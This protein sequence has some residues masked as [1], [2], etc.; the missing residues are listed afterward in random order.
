MTATISESQNDST[1]S[2]NSNSNPPVYQTVG[3]EK[4]YPSRAGEVVAL[5]KMDLTIQRGEF[6]SIRGA[7][8]S[9]K[10]TLLMALGGMSH[11]TSGKILF[12][13]SDLYQLS[14]GQR[15]Q[16]RAQSIGFIF[17]MF[18]LAPYLN[19]M[20]NTLLAWHKSWYKSE[21]GQKPAD[22]AKEILSQLGLSHRLTHRPSALSAGERQRA[23]IARALFNRPAAILADEPTGNL[24]PENAR[25]VFEALHDFHA[26]GG[27]VILVT[28]G[29]M[30][31]E[32]ASR[33]IHLS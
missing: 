9:G 25:G 2:V 16:Y 21:G 19:I 26:N 8:G 22:R 6:L 10:T 31:A 4:I 18:H 27:T 32:F 17:Q 24:D 15:A 20:E 11:P 33:E 3:V 29:E 1:Q 12:E 30:G 14:P 28:H 23:A 7:S 13:G 5:K